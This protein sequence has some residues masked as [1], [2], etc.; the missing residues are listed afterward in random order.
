MEL[1]KMIKSLV[2]VGKYFGRSALEAAVIYGLFKVQ[3]L[4]D[5][6]QI[7]EMIGM[8]T[9]TRYAVDV[10]DSSFLKQGRIYENIFRPLKESYKATPVKE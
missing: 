3:G 10:F 5:D 1:E 2:G 6:P 9:L 4:L 8:Y 7:I